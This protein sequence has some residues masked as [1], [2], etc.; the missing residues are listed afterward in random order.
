M[1]SGLGGSGLRAGPPASGRGCTRSARRRSARPGGR[2]RRGTGCGRARARAR[3]GRRRRAGSRAPRTCRRTRRAP[4]R[5][6]NRDGLEFSICGAERERVDV[7]DGVDRRVPGDPVAVR[8]EDLGLLAGRDVGILDQRV[9]Q[10]LDDEPVQAR[11]RGPLVRAPGVRLLEVDH[12]HRIEGR[13][14]GDELLRPAR[15]RVELEPHALERVQ[16]L[17]ASVRQRRGDDEGHRPRLA[18]EHLVERAGRSAGAPGRA[19]RSRTPSGGSP[20]SPR[21]AARAS[22]ACARRRGRGSGPPPGSAAAPRRRR[23]RPPPRPPRRRRAGG[24]PSC[25]GRSPDRAVSSSPSSAYDSTVRG[26]PADE[27]DRC[28]SGGDHDHERN[29]QEHHQRALDPREPVARP[30]SAIATTVIPSSHHA[31]NACDA[32]GGADRDEEAGM[33]SPARMLRLFELNAS[34]TTA[35]PRPWSAS[36]TAVSTFGSARQRG[37]HERPDDDVRDAPAVAEVGRRLHQPDARPMITA[38]AAGR[39]RPRRALSPAAPRSVRM[40]SR[41]LLRTAAPSSRRTRPGRT[42]AERRTGRT[43]PR[44]ARCAATAPIAPS[45]SAI[46]G[47]R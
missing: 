2:A 46:A 9:R 25:A 35:A 26:R 21:T 42:R 23:S 20:P 6:P 30:A 43:R 22:R 39:G 38:S 4:A 8:L 24:S 15:L 16:P 13:E 17:R 10:R 27:V 1:E 18:P 29:V 44:S 3:T 19:R 5:E 37:E 36:R 32:R 28:S 33:A 12:V 11:R 47:A 14:L 45:T 7:G 31:E 40:S 41:L 34:L